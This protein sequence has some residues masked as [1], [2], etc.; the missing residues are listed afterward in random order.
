MGNIT[1]KIAATKDEL[2]QSLAVRRTVFIEEQQIAAEEEYDGQDEAAL[3]FI[4]LDGAQVI[5]TARL[6][7][8]AAASA[9]IERMAVLK[10]FR[11]QGIGRGILVCIEQELKNRHISQAVLHAQTTAAP[12]YRACGFKETGSIFQEAGIPHIK[13][14]K[15][16]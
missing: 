15:Q 14:S 1:F 4:A 2:R 12:F 5:G 16:L 8:S 9:K 13:M 3:H 6:R 11:Q 10:P 7:F